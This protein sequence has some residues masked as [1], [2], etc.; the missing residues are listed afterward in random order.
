MTGDAERLAGS[1]RGWLSGSRGV[2]QSRSEVVFRG[3]GAFAPWAARGVGTDV[4]GGSAPFRADRD[5]NLCR[6]AATEEHDIHGLSHGCHFDL[7]HEVQVVF[8]LDRVE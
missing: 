7:V 2:R 5:L 3:V 6:L 4:C 8:D 1:C